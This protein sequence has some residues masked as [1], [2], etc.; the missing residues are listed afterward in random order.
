M[1]KL[2]TTALA[3]ALLVGLTSAAIAEDDWL[4]GAEL[5]EKIVG[6][7]VSGLTIEGYQWSETYRS[8]GTFVVRTHD[9][10]TLAGLWDIDGDLMCASLDAY[11]E[12]GSCLA[13]RLDGDEVVYISEH[14]DSS[15]T[16][17]LS[18]ESTL[19]FLTAEEIAANIIGG[20]I[21]GYTADGATWSET[22]H[23]DG[24]FSGTG[25]DGGVLTGRWEIDDT[26][27]CVLY[28]GDPVASCWAIRL[29]GDKVR[30]V[31]EHGSDGGH[32]TLTR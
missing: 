1:R 29:D 17:V 26:F 16:G 7:T 13:M 23:A 27:L 18:F 25:V 3:A 19:D 11:P 31:S 15:E 30:Y 28:D 10:Q 4:S 9:G 8:D 21:T 12:E 20:T 2:Q 32:G 5:Q 24:A 14:G 6:G 22:Y